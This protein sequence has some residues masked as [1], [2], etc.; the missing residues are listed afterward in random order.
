MAV[1]SADLTALPEVAATVRVGGRRGASVPA[2]LVDVLAASLP[3]TGTAGDEDED[4]GD[5]AQAGRGED[6][7][8]GGAVGSVGID[9]I[10]ATDTTAEQAE[11]NKV[12]NEGDGGDEEAQTGDDGGDE[13]ADSV[14]AEGKEE[15]DEEK[16][17][18]DGVQDHDVGE[19]AD[20]GLTGIRNLDNVLAA[21]GQ[22]EGHLDIVADVRVA[23]APLV[24]GLALDLSIY[25]PTPTTIV[26]IVLSNLNMEERDVVDHRSRDIGDDE[27]DG[28]HQE[29][30]GADVV[31]KGAHAHFEKRLAESAW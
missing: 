25:T 23:A 22:V 3:A 13:G 1:R 17:G 20:S 19:A 24:G 4:G 16:A 8:H 5:Q 12:A 18:G 26:D 31:N 9:T 29:E 28:R 30:E 21:A 2:L 7:P 15:G 11:A 6:T 27:E 10:G 14:G